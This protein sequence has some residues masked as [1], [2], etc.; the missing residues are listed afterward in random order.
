MKGYPHW[1]LPALLACGLVGVRLLAVRQGV[2]GL[3]LAAL[4][5]P[6]GVATLLLS[7]RRYRQGRLDLAAGRPLADGRLGL[8]VTGQV[9]L[10]G[11]VSTWLVLR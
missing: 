4:L 8:L 3:V 7:Q 11:L 10:L 5:L 1:F 6:A 2:A 9:A